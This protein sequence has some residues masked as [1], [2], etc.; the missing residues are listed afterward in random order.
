MGELGETVKRE[1]SCWRSN[2]LL[3][4]TFTCT[5]FN[6]SFWRQTEHQPLSLKTGEYV[7][8]CQVMLCYV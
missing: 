6:I 7:I 2:I 5:H 8:S 1:N 4:T 3:I